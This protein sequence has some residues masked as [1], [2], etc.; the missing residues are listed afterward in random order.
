[1]NDKLEIGLKLVGSRLGFIQIYR[2]STPYVS[3]FVAIL[4]HFILIWYDLILQMQNPLD[5]KHL[6]HTNITTVIS[7]SGYLK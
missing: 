1:M 3:K 2:T 4:S 7:G 6:K 5:P